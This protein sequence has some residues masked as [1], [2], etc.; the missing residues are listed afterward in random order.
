MKCRSEI[1]RKVSLLAAVGLGVVFLA[2]CAS[3]GITLFELVPAQ[4]QV[5]TVSIHNDQVVLSARYLDA[6]ERMTYLREKG[7][8]FLGLGL[9]QVSLVTFALSV[10]NGSDQ[11]LI[12]DPGSIRLAV[13]YGPL[14]SPYN[15]A[16]LYME[17]PR[18]S[19]RQRV[20]EDLR[21]VTFDKSTTILPGQMNEKLLLF[22]RP[23]LVGPEAAVLFERLYLG[24]EELK[25]LLE[26]KTVDLGK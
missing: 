16:H 19:N 12:L 8:E 9:R 7:S 26:F 14:L 6:G 25:T 11:K 13:G 2:S 4:G 15:Y 10:D 23:E 17:L 21:K 5:S 3:T 20:L 22:K 24:G 1:I 18:G